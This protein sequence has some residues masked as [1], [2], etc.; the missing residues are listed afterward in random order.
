MACSGRIPSGLED[1]NENEPKQM[2]M[3]SF[4]H[5]CLF[6]RSVRVHTSAGLDKLKSMGENYFDTGRI[7]IEPSSPAMIY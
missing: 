6:L 2:G 1:S 7:Y 5:V 3:S 4:L